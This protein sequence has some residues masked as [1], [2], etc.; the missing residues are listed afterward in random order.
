[1]WKY[2]NNIYHTSWRVPGVSKGFDLTQF[3]SINQCQPHIWDFLIIG[4]QRLYEYLI[5]YILPW[6]YSYSFLTMGN[7]IVITF[8]STSSISSI[9]FV[10][11]S[12]TNQTRTY[13]REKS[14]FMQHLYVWPFGQS[15]SFHKKQAELGVPHSEL[16][17]ELDW[18]F[19]WDQVSVQCG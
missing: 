17:V 1:M 14:S 5:F 18:Y 6:R 19:N 3:Y 11:P 7:L 16:Q 2:Y 13:Q 12:Y 8:Y 15:N 4:R 10:F 9:G